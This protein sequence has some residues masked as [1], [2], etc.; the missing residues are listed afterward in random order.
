MDGLV[1]LAAVKVDSSGK[2]EEKGT[3]IVSPFKI[4]R[5]DE[6]QNELIWC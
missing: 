6:K 3:R 5:C 2:K 1:V 4:A